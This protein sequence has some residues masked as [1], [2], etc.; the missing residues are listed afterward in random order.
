MKEFSIYLYHIYWS[1]VRFERRFD[2][3]L[4][5]SLSF[6]R[7]ATSAS[8]KLNAGWARTEN[9]DAF[10]KEQLEFSRN[11]LLI[12]HREE[13]IDVMASLE[14]LISDCETLQHTPAV[15]EALNTVR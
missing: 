9:I 15:N 6:M 8:R 14:K 11:V 12:I 3:L 13:D 10:D 7:W 2:S 4:A 5:K 1:V